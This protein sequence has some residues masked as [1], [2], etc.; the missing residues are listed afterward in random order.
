MSTIAFGGTFPIQPT[1]VFTIP[2]GGDFAIRQP[3]PPVI[4]VLL[5]FGGDF[6]VKPPARSINL[7]ALGGD[8]E[9]VRVFVKS[10]G[11]L[12]DTVSGETWP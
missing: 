10:G 3:T 11:A 1:G 8:L 4:P 2:F 7:V 6:E 5:V 9:S 12:V